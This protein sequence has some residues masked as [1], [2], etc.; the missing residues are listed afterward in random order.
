MV[1]KKEIYFEK[2]IP[3]HIISRAV[4]GRKIFLGE[5]DALRFIFQMY[6]ANVGSPGYSLHRR[7]INKIAQAI[8][9]G[10]QISQRFVTV[11][12][13]PLV[14][15]LS[16]ALSINHHH[17]ISLQ[18]VEGGLSKYLQKLHGGFAKYFNLKHGRKDILF[19]RQSKIIPIQSNFQL[20]AV[21]RYVNIKNPL[22]VY[23]PGWRE[24]GLKNK[25]TALEFLNQYPFSSFPDL[26]GQ[27]DSKI[28]APKEILEK[29]LGKEIEENQRSFLNFI[30]DYL[31]NNLLT[32][33][34]LFLEEE[35]E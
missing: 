34:P 2:V 32:H 5:N 12:H 22:D 33:Y 8:L 21:I 30:E 20:D 18:N 7:D 14:D 13:P 31:Q 25:D 29:Y 1:S 9:N 26:F 35:L 4:E 27:R 6:A 11:K 28:L 15:H 17:F 23:Q 19:E 16:F 10:E 24:K 3:L